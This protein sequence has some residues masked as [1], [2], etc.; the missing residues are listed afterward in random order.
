MIA[1]ALTAALL[2]QTPTAPEPSPFRPQECRVY[3]AHVSSAAAYTG[4]GGGLMGVGLVQA[5]VLLRSYM[6]ARSDAPEGVETPFPTFEAAVYGTSAVLGTVL[7]VLG[8]TAP[9]AAC[10]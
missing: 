9:A 1:I 2:T 3:P 6:K 4:T 10:Y 8:M 7:L 5:V